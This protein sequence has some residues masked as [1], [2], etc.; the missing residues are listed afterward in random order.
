MRKS[1]IVVSASAGLLLA[2]CSSSSKAAQTLPPASAAGGSSAS[3]VAA[4]SSPSVNITAELLAVSDLPAGW[5]ST[6]D[7]GSSGGAASCAALNNRPWQAL[8]E[9]AEADFQQSEIGPFIA[10]KL[11]AGPSAQVAQAWAAFASATA[12]CRSFSGQTSSGTAQYKLSSLSFPS[13]GDQTYA[14]A[15]TV[16]ASGISASGDVVVVRKGGTLVQ[17]L[18]LGIPDVPVSTVEQ[19]TSAAVAKVK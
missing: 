17:I 19:F 10:E 3:A 8:P 5:S 15:I 14:F 4:Q 12:T 11:D 9:R 2:A 6:S 7:S 13:Y 16:T 18:A 1:L